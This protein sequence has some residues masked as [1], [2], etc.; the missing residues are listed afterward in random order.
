M[1][2]ERRKCRLADV[3]SRD[4]DLRKYAPIIIATIEKTVAGKNP[5]VNKDYFSTDPLTQTEAVMLGHVQASTKQSESR[6][7]SLDLRQTF[8]S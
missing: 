5:K 3:K 7:V 4:V 1:A 2:N 6:A 8:L